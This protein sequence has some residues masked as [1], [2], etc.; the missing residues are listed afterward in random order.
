MIKHLEDHISTRNDAGGYPP[1]DIV[2]ITAVIFMIDLSGRYF[3]DDSIECALENYHLS[4]AYNR[5]NH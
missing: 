2:D 5:S 3:D 1:I 4:N